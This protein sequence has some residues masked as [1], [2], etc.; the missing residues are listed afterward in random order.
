MFSS[1]I[2]LSFRCDKETPKLIYIRYH[3]L[4]RSSPYNPIDR[5]VLTMIKWEHERGR[6]KLQNRDKKHE[7]SAAMSP[8]LTTC[9]KLTSHFFWKC[10]W[11][12]SFCV[13]NETWLASCKVDTENIYLCFK[14]ESLSDSFP[15]DDCEN[16]SLHI[17]STRL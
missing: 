9:L 5:H 10:V 12:F 15:N 4:I 3:I 7:K 6:K 16:L 13:K 2:D 11:G 1:L 14:V 8:E 17:H